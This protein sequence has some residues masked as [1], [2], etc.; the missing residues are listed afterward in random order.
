MWKSAVDYVI[1]SLLHLPAGN[2]LTGALHFFIYDTVKIFF[3]L[4]VIIFIISF[5]RTYFSAAR[6]RALLGNR[7]GLFGNVL[8]ALLGIVTPFCSC[9]AVPLFIGFVEA[10]IPLGVT[11]SFLIASP[12]INEV[13]LVM[14]AGLFGWKVALIYIASGLIIAIA[15]G[16]VIGFLKLETWVEPFVFET[17]VGTVIEETMTIRSRLIYA[18]DYVGGILKKIWPFV[19]TAI[20][21]GAFIHGY[22]P[23]NFFANYLGADAWY[24]VPLATLLGVPLYSNAAGV[25]PVVE[26]LF[27]KGV[28]LGTAL[29]FMMAVTGLSFP[30]FIILRRVLKL[31]LLA[32]FI[33]VVSAG[34]MITGFLFNA[35]HIGR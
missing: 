3:L 12:M 19:L 18:R 34:I 16:I 10:G 22:V 17:R 25:I 32:V 24:A 30:E 27:A 13:A 5:I 11:F 35:L 7:L 33:G 6:T 2:R 8:A 15:S 4:A 9:S 28:P 29:A 26:A 23:E 1:F 21:I 31:K 14:L 20:A